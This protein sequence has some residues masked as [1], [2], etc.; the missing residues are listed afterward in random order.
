[1]QHFFWRSNYRLRTVV[2]WQGS[3][4]KKCICNPTLIPVGKNDCKAMRRSRQL[5]LAV[6]LCVASLLTLRSSQ[7]GPIFSGAARNGI[8]ELKETLNIDI[9][10]AAKSTKFPDS[11][12][13]QKAVFNSSQLVWG[14]RTDRRRKW[15]ISGHCRGIPGEQ[16]GTREREQAED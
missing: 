16:T 3:R 5:P 6:Y 4:G 15:W 11:S 1:M 10:A 14:L 13:A 9:E 8:Q 7:Q 12:L 2:L